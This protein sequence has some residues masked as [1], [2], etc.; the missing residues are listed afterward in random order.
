MSAYRTKVYENYHWQQMTANKRLRVDKGGI[1]Y[2]ICPE[3]FEHI[4]GLTMIK[5]ERVLY[6]VTPDKKGN[7]SSMERGDDCYFDVKYACPKCKAILTDSKIEAE[8][9]F[10]ETEDEHKSRMEYERKK[11]EE[12]QNKSKENADK[13]TGKEV[14]K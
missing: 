11:A 3:C 6:S 8:A 10:M 13:A 7:F 2:A 4:W 1:P 9:L 5:T 14:S 12:E